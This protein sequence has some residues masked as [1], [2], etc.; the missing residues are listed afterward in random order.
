MMAWCICQLPSSVS[1][2]LT[3]LITMDMLDASPT[4]IQ[5]LVGQLLLQGELLAPGS[6]R[7]HGESD[8]RQRERQEAQI[9]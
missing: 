3:P 6:L 2:R 8:L 4:I 5:G 1:N 9:L 7:R